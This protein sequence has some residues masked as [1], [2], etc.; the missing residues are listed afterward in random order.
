MKTAVPIAQGC[1]DGRILGDN[2]Q[3]HIQQQPCGV[4]SHSQAWAFVAVVGDCHHL[5]VIKLRHSSDAFPCVH[6]GKWPSLCPRCL[7]AYEFYKH[8][9][10]L[11]IVHIISQQIPGVPGY[12]C[13]SPVDCRGKGCWVP[14]RQEKI[15]C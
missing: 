2:H 11:A 7:P 4:T 12:P 10:N 5:P 1:V 3:K 6:H 9:L 13:V 14:W 15:L 8:A